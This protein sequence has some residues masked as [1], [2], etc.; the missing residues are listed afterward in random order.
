[1]DWIDLAQNRGSGHEPSCFLK[2]GEFFFGV[3]EN[4]LTSQEGLCSMEFRLSR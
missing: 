2:C 4:L 1:M 3:G